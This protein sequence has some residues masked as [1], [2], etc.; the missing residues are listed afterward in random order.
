MDKEK[1]RYFLY[2]YFNH[3]ISAADCIELLNYLNSVNP[4]EIADIID[5]ELFSL[6]EG[7]EFKDKQ[8]NELFS[9]IR[10]DPRYIGASFRETDDKPQVVKFY[11]KSW[12]QIAAVLLVCCAA[13]LFFIKSG[14]KDQTLTNDVANIQTPVKILPGSN[15]ATLTLPNG[16]VIPLETANSDLIAKLGKASAVKIREGQLIYNNLQKDGHENLLNNVPVYHLISTP[17]GGEYQV[18]LSDGTKVWL[19]SASS[20]S[21]PQEFTGNARHVKLHGEA[22]FEVAKNKDMPFYVSIN[23][24]EVKVLGTH[25]NIAAYG[26]DKQITATLL[27]GSV[28]ISKNHK[29]SLLKPGQQVVV[30]NSNDEIKVSEANIAEAMAWRNEYFIFNND[31]IKS[32]MKKVSR[33]YD[34]DVEY[35]G[36]FE[37]QRFGGTF[38][39]FKS[40]NELLHHLEEIG[41]IHFK[42]MGRRVIVTE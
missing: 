21:F 17:K 28:Q 25:F 41:D 23:N 26:D 5:L 6:D 9:R 40:I 1:L 37:N 29:Q 36:S 30:N 18:V 38:Y 14:P 7:P 2:Q 32:I 39:R 42:I 33:W 19:N 13:G 31:D 12:L 10:S 20:L 22:Y 4:D 24:V 16:K 8:A 34:V 27:E 3:T 15:K 35:Q 11:Q